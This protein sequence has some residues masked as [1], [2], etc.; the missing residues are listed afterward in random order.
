MKKTEVATVLPSFARERLIAAARVGK[1]GS[2]ERAI[3]INAAIR[4]AKEK[5]PTF[6]LGEF[7]NENKTE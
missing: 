3:A 6:F 7:N 5:Y 4:Y 2:F 1:P